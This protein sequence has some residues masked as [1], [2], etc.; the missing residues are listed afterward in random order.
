MLRC[1]ILL[2]LVSLNLMVWLDSPGQLAIN[3]DLQTG[4]KANPKVNQQNIDLSPIASMFAENSCLLLHPQSLWLLCGQGA[5]W[6]IAKFSAHGLTG[7]REFDSKSGRQNILKWT[8][9][10]PLSLSLVL[11]A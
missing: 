9:L 5:D 10:M 7:F 11:L 8:Q 2:I 1:L 3:E 4:E 6:L